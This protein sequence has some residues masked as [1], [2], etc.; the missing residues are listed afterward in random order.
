[1][2]DKT[3][4]KHYAS[5]A[6]SEGHLESCTMHDEAI[7]K[8]ET[9]FIINEIKKYQEKFTI[10]HS[11]IRYKILDVGCGNGFTLSEIARKFNNLE[12]SGIEFTPELRSLANKKNLPCE[13]KYGDVRD[14]TSI[15]PGQN[16]LISQ[17][18]IINLLNK[19]DQKNAVLNL[20]NSTTSEGYLIFIEA[21]A[22][23]LN[24]LNKCRTELGL[25]KIP[26]AHHNLYLEDNFFEQ[27]ENIKKV[28]TEL[29]ENVLST[30][31]FISRVLHDVAL[32]GTK[33]KFVRRS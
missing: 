31:Y 19:E 18:V 11:K 20:I 17:R 24:N 25:R 7:R 21:F 15:P 26:P 5:V 23:G 12:L 33:G 4:L 16:L 1:M 30:H 6:S 2:Y 9:K 22:N 27:F 28:E 29:G 3:I 13:V 32:S 10:K 14:K 8:L